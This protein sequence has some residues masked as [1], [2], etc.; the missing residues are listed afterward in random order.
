MSTSKE[1][2]VQQRAAVAM[3]SSNRQRPTRALAESSECITEITNRAGQGSSCSA[4]MA[5]AEAR[6]AIVASRKAA[7]RRDPVHEAVIAEE[8]RYRHTSSRKVPTEGVARHDRTQRG[9]RKPQSRSGTA[10]H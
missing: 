3:E 1:L 6:T 9:T 8:A 10:V 7:R 2:T 5:A 4:A